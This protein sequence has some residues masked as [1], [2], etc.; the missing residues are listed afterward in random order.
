MSVNPRLV[1]RT[2]LVAAV[3]VAALVAGIVVLRALHGGAP[4]AGPAAPARPSAYPEPA[5]VLGDDGVH[6]P[7]MVRKPDGGYLL[8]HTGDNLR[9]KTSTDLSTFTDAGAVF[10]DGAAWTT[11]FTK[12]S[13]ALWAPDISFHGGRYYLYYS[14]S[15]F[16]SNRSAIFLATSATGESGSWTHE[17]LVIES[18]PGSDYNAIDPNLYVDDT[19]RWWLTFGSFWTGIKQMSL[20]PATGRPSRAPASLTALATRGDTAIEAPY[21]VKHGDHYYLW[22]SFDACCK[23]AASTY[24]TMVGR[25]TSPE[26]PFT[27]RDG[28]PMTAGGG[29]EVLSGHGAVHGPGHPAVLDDLLIYHYYPDSGSSLL[30]LNHIGYDADGWPFAY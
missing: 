28:T 19:G 8:A 26:G 14:A 6:D 23:G 1:R 25:S 16:G 24:R 29:T 30:G 21:L 10:P 7:T 9:L 3:V 15:T 2:A 4:A 11:T 13:T 17:G 22:V 27:D 18:G 12:G 5:F 20:D